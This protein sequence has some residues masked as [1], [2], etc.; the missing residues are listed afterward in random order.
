MS[1]ISAA[2]ILAN[3]SYII[4]TIVAFAMLIV[5]IGYILLALFDRS[6]AKSFW[7]VYAIVE[8]ILAVWNISVYYAKV[9]HR[10]Q[11]AHGG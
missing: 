8:V 1:R 5:A 6:V 4:C 10:K 9:R 2:P 7:W 11:R 3:R